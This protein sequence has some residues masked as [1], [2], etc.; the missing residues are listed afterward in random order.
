MDTFMKLEPAGIIATM[1]HR[2]FFIFLLL[3]C[4]AAV[5][6]LG[7]HGFDYY[8][9][10]VPS[11]PFLS[12]HEALKASGTYSHGLGILGSALVVVGVSVYSTRK[13]IKA[14]WRLGKLSTWL[15][16]HIAVC[17]LGPILVIFHTT[18]KA[19]GVAAISLWTMLSVWL[20]GMVGRFLY[21][22]IP[23]NLQGNE[24][25]GEQ[26]KEELSRL[27]AD[28]C[29]TSVGQGLMNQIDRR[30]SLVKR[31]ESI[32]GTIRT[33]VH[34]VSIRRELQHATR[35]VIAGGGL[36]RTSASRLS[37]ATNERIVLLRKSIA[38]VQVQKLFHY[39][40]AI[41]LPFTVIMFITLAAHVA[42]TVLIGYTW[43]F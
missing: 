4:L 15:E 13:R 5:L 25:S 38:L 7:I 9:T 16:F 34:L 30:F 31:P 40:H 27:A 20:S 28:I 12:N 8:F 42:V 24:L 26:V 35:V 18:F 22:Q 43:I 32:M 23:R 14:F 3:I 19:G 1:E 29:T 33:L 39:W 41:H 37:R 21:V 6:V 10:P 2:V 17:L 36:S 11:R